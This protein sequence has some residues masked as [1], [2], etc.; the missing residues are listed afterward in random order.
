MEL[1]GAIKFLNELNQEDVSFDR[2]F[3]K[4]TG[5]R[6]ISEGMV[7]SFLSQS[8]KL[9][10]VE[11]GRNERF[12][13]WFKMSTKYSLVLIIDKGFSKG[14]KVIS[15]WNTNRKWQNKLKR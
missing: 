15:T 12:K 13:L 2:H 8:N 6:P 3:Y 5:E 11:E 9:E 14:L 7:R 10:K 4:R 1:E